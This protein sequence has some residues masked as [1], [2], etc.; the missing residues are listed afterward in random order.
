MPLFHRTRASAALLAALALAAPLQAQ[1]P[2]DRAGALVVRAENPLAADRPDETIS[3]PWAALRQAH[4]G[5]Q[6]DRVRVLDAGTRTEVVSQPLDADGD[7]TVDELL[8]QTGFRPGEVREF[9]V[10]AAPSAP[11]KPRVHARH[12]AHRDDVAWESDRI[13][14]RIYGQ[15]LWQ[16]S[17]YQPLVSSGIDVW[18]KRVRDLVVERWYAKGHDAYHLDTGEGADFYT[19]GPTLGAG[20]SAVWRGGEL[21]RAKN[22]RSHRIL[23]TG[24]IR[25]VFELRYDPWDAAGMQVSETK[26]VSIDAGQN[27]FRQEITYH[28]PGAAEVPYAVGTVKR[29]GLVGSSRQEA[30]WAWVSTW[31]PVERKNG[32]HGHLGTAV[33][34][35]KGRM[36][37][38]R[39]TADHYLALATARPGVPTVQYVGSGWTASGD[40]R[41]VEDWWRHVDAFGARLAN[42]VKVTLLRNGAPLAAGR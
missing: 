10:E 38:A 8:F 17:E 31:G 36:A 16:A 23:A 35:E 21:H 11:A 4:P 12:D 42:P 27:F 9:V 39:E 18:P 2:A 19:V 14:F 32:G 13:A 30:P 25:A 34:M 33:L 37:E 6:A 15:G 24:P 40:F 20:G 29:E 1:R 7:G 28:A 41:T 22:F 5:L 3:L 26:R